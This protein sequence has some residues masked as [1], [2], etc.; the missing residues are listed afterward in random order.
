MGDNDCCCQTSLKCGCGCCIGLAIGGMF[1]SLGSVA[2]TPSLESTIA[3]AELEQAEMQENEGQAGKQEPPQGF[4]LRQIARYQVHI[5]PRLKQAL[6]VERLCPYE[7]SCSE[8]AR[9]AIE[10]Y[11]SVRGSLMAAGRLAR[12]NPFTK[13]G[14]DPVA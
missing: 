9:Q 12:C 3:A 7:P 4:L 6:R 5:S 13:G 11:G 2:V 8:Y 14:Y 1:L 10:Q